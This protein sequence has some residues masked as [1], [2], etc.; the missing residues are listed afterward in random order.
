VAID[1]VAL[2]PGASDA[3]LRLTFANGISLCAPRLCGVR[4][5]EAD[6]GA[7]WAL[8][9]DTVDGTFLRMAFRATALPDELDAIAPG[10][11]PADT[12]ASR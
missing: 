5:Q 3:V 7:E 2:V 9:A 12:S 1:S 4:I 6:D 10:E 11:A 8:E